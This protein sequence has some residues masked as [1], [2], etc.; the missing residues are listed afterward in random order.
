MSAAVFTGYIFTASAVESLNQT[1]VPSFYRVLLYMM[2]F[3]FQVQFDFRTSKVKNLGAVSNSPS[4]LPAFHAGLRYVWIGRRPGCL[5]RG[6]LQG[7]FQNE[8]L[9]PERMSHSLNGSPHRLKER[10]GAARK[11]RHWHLL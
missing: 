10:M 9:A 1:R 7:R 2:S 5:P 6:D 8:D 3:A 11:G 4:V